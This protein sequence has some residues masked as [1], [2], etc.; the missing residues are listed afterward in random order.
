MIVSVFWD[1]PLC[2]LVHILPQS[3][4]SW[5]DRKASL[6][7]TTADM[8][9]HDMM[10]CQFISCQ[11]KRQ[12]CANKCTQNY[13]FYCELQLNAS[14]RNKKCHSLNNGQISSSAKN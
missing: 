2:S 11:S 12:L 13:S 1:V 6:Q 4:S 9:R 8:L 14:G 5:A 10:T 3:I 7:Y